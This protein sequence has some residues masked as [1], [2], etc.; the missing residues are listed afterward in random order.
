MK[1]E[2]VITIKGTQFVDGDKDS[3]ELTTLGTFYRK[4][5]HYYLSS[6]ES[7]ATGFAGQR[8]TLKIEGDRR[9]TMIRYGGGESSLIVEKS[10]RHQCQYDTGY[11]S[12]LIGVNGDEIESHLTDEGGSYRFKYSLDIN[13]ALVSTNE[14]F[15]TVKPTENESIES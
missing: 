1:K 6:L 5:D 11:G 4:N 8:T 7:E 3:V 12:L 13:T 10:V 9:V 2:A 14:I 15:V